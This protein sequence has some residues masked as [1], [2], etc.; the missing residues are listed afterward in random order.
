MRLDGLEC[1]ARANLL[2]ADDER[3]V[4]RLATRAAGAEGAAPRARA[5]PAHSSGPARCKGSGT[6]EIA[7]LL[8]R[9]DSRRR[10]ATLTRVASK[11]P[12]APAT[13]DLPE[14]LEASTLP[15]EL[16]RAELE[17]CL[18]EGLDLSERDASRL[19]LVESR[20]V[21]VDLT[22]SSLRHAT[23]RDVVDRGGKLG[24][25]AR[26]RR[27]AATPALRAGASDRRR[28]RRRV[29]RGRHLRR[30]PDRSR[31]VPGG[32]ARERPLRGLPHGGGRLPGGDLLLL[33]LLRLRPY[34]REPRRGD[35]RALR[36]ARLRSRG[37]SATR[38]G[39]AACA[40]RGPTSVNAA[41]ELAE[42]TGIEIVD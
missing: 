32:E 22:G 13:P 40:C 36:A 17:A 24:E 8:M 1:I 16:A 37:R 30:L 28:S 2:A 5:S 19:A 31:V 21:R 12:I 14:E 7:W 23:L 38:N 35:V 34:P 11:P 41:A 18:L 20:L 27:D 26:C 39:C 42:A 33:S 10:D 3:D 4:E 15:D 9:G 6:R 25:R 29:D